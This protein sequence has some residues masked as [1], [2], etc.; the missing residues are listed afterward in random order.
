S[1]SRIRG[2]EHEH[3]TFR[4]TIGNPPSAALFERRLHMLILPFTH[5]FYGRE[6]R[7]LTARL[8]DELPSILLWAIDG[9]SRLT[10]RGYFV[11]PQAG[12]ELLGEL[13]D[14]ASPVSAFVRERCVVGELNAAIPVAD[15]FGEWKA[16]TEERGWKDAG[17]EQDFGKSIRAYVPGLKLT[18]PRHRVSGRPV[19]TYGGIRLRTP[20]DDDGTH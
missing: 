7:S 9:W 5:S 15:L 12:E 13:S 20:S 6:D 2:R 14:L 18:H 3:Y 4:P 1:R 17:R 8:L 19:R 11:Q 10:E 16:W